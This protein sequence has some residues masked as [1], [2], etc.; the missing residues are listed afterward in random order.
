[1]NTPITGNDDTVHTCGVSEHLLFEYLRLTVGTGENCATI[2]HLVDAY[3][4]PLTQLTHRQHS[5]KSHPKSDHECVCNRTD[6]RSLLTDLCS[7]ARSTSF[8][9]TSRI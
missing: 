7:R 4:E 6:L 9:Q 3:G 1:M 2:G 5:R 8:V